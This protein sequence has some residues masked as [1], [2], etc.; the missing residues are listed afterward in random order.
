MRYDDDAW[1]QTADRVAGRLWIT[2][3]RPDTKATEME[4]VL[5][6]TFLDGRIHRIWE[7]TWPDWSALPEFEN[8]ESL[9]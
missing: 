4:I 3:E 1:V 5:I 7:V 2:T 8:Y 9:E 6:A